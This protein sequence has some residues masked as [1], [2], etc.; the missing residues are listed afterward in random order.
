MGCY[1]SAVIEAP[2]DQVDMSWSP[3]VIEKLDAEGDPRQIGARRVLNDAFRETLLALDDVERTVRYSIDDGPGPVSKDSVQGYIGEI[4]VSPVTDT[5][6][7][8]VVWTSRWAASSGGV[9]E[10][11]NPIY[12][13]LLDD[14]KQHFAQSRVDR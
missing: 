5:N 9:E 6:S 10:F 4:Q 13:A 8:F 7:T 12:K 11:C 14:L 1:N 2:L 3:N